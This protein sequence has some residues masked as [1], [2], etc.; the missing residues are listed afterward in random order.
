MEQAM[1]S[2]ITAEWQTSTSADIMRDIK[3]MRDR[4]K[5]IDMEEV[6]CMMCGDTQARCMKG[7]WLC[8]YFQ[9]PRTICTGCL[10]WL[11][12]EAVKM[13]EIRSRDA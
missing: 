7:M 6:Q 8:A 4:M 5:E 9:R 13:D 10:A 3:G 12:G 11:H 2:L 1:N